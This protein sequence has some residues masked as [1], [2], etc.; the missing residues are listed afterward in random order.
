AVCGDLSEKTGQ[1]GF[2][3]PRRVQPGTHTD[4]PGGLGLEPGGWS[5]GSHAAVGPADNLYRVRADRE[6]LRHAAGR[7]DFPSEVH[8]P[9][10]RVRGHIPMAL[11]P[12]QRGD[13]V[14]GAGL[15]VVVQREDD[16]AAAV[17]VH[18]ERLPEDRRVADP[19]GAAASPPMVVH[20][21]HDLIRAT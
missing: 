20:P 21:D 18:G 16:L 10:L 15:L 3:L 12:A 8:L 19:G 11:Q 7:A 14:G 17:L 13:D 4:E 1:A 2:I 6:L 5:L 9:D